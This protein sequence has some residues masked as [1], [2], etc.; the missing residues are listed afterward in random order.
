M[1]SLDAVHLFLNVL[2]SK[3]RRR[4]HQQTWKLHFRHHRQV[5]LSKELHMKFLI[6]S[7]LLLLHCFYVAKEILTG[8]WGNQLHLPKWKIGENVRSVWHRVEIKLIE[9]TSIQNR[10]RAGSLSK[11]IIIPFIIRAP[12][13]S[14]IVHQSKLM[15]RV[16][17]EGNWKGIH[18]SHGKA[19]FSSLSLCV[20]SDIIKLDEETYENAV[21]F[22]F[23]LCFSKTYLSHRTDKIY[24]HK[25]E[26]R[27]MYTNC[28]IEV[29]KLSNCL[30]LKN[31]SSWRNAM[32]RHKTFN[33][34]S[35]KKLIV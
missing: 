20:H 27:L 21:F 32:W 14:A 16:Y 18:S 12:S 23:F 5:S 1:C 3:R 2:I 19:F 15:T 29:S 9:A 6:V 7:L 17:A 26:M 13:R 35:L 33:I 28:W 30:M 10:H 22:E 34:I 4:R 31:F 11:W 24:T 25:F 8:T